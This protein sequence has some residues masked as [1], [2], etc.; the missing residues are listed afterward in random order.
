MFLI[1]PTLQFT[2]CC[3]KSGDSGHRSLQC[4]SCNAGLS[5]STFGATVPCFYLV[6][7]GWF[8]ILCICRSFKDI[9]IQNFVSNVV[10]RLRYSGIIGMV[11][12]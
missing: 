4:Y 7:P 2:S 1:M 8:L 5:G 3:V 11:E 6:P 10:M 9:I 12:W